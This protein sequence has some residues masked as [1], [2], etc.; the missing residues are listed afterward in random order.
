[1]EPCDFSL[2]DEFEKNQEEIKDRITESNSY[3]GGVDD[4]PYIIALASDVKVDLNTEYG[5]IVKMFEEDRVTEP[6]RAFFGKMTGRPVRRKDYPLAL[7]KK[8]ANLDQL[9]A[10]HNAVKYPVT[11]IQGPPGTGKSYT[12]VNTVV[13]AFFNEKTVLLS[14]YNNHPLDTVVENLKTIEYQR[15]TMVPFPVLRLGNEKVVSKSLKEVRRLYEQVKGLNVFES[16]LDRNRGDKIRRTQQLTALLTDDEQSFRT[17]LNF[18]SAKYL[19]RLGE[20]KNEDL[21]KSLFMEEEKRNGV[22]SFAHSSG[23]NLML[24][25]DPQQ[26]SPVILL[27]AKDNEIL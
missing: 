26:L 19:K 24:V 1:M 20:P 23:K 22:V 12:I 14:S 13:T 18:T 4:R 7:L 25:G 6:I 17:Y 15:G 27:D 11:Y 5:A 3:I 10:I 2:L 8:Q 9:L 16:T 21:L